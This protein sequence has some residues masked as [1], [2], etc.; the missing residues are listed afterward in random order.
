M[1]DGKVRQTNDSVLHDQDSVDNKEDE[2]NPAPVVDQQGIDTQTTVDQRMPGGLKDNSK[3]K[4]SDGQNDPTIMDQ[5][6]S[7]KVLD[8]PS[9]QKENPSTDKPEPDA[10]NSNQLL[11]EESR[12]GGQEHLET[13]QNENAE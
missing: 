2:A 9:E 5:Y 8:V 3:A 10:M 1:R 13:Y 4:E 11:K 12:D 6:G 7:Q